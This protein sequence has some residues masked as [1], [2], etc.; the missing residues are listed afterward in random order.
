MFGGGG[1]QGNVGTVFCD[2][3]SLAHN[4]WQKRS[5]STSPRARSGAAMAYDSG[6]GRAHRSGRMRLPAQSRSEP[7]RQVLRIAPQIWLWAQSG[8][9]R[10]RSQ[11]GTLWAR[12]LR[13]GRR[14]TCSF[15]HPVSRQG[16]FY[17]GA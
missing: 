15:F 16:S 9:I 4:A 11:V 3:R 12:R 10:P 5:P 14:G 6:C 13:T 1:V 8:F 7:A 2:T 17:A